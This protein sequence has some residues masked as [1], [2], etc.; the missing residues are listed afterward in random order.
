MVTILIVSTFKQYT[1][2][3]QLLQWLTD[4]LF[5]SSILNGKQAAD[6][7]TISTDHEP[8]LHYS[9]EIIFISVPKN[10][11][12]K[13]VGYQE[14]NLSHYRKLYTVDFDFSRD[15]MSDDVHSMNETT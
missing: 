2:F 4:L 9:F 15:F 8:V 14:K 10:F 1:F 13:L 6:H 3:T 12:R 7:L 11:I 5:K